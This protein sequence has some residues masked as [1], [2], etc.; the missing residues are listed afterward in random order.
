MQTTATCPDWAI[1]LV[2]QACKDYKRSLPT[3]LQWYQTANEHSS[4]H[5]DYACTRM[6][7]TAGNQKWECRAVLIHELA[8]Y[9]LGK[10]KWGRKQRHSIHFWRLYWQL[11]ERYGSVAENYE[12]DVTLAR[13]W[14]PNTNAWAIHT[15]AELPK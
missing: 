10:T 2:T 9:L 3:K 12:R 4:G 11:A 14:R 8:H 5:V 13:Q 7:V 1:E 6:H 15:Y